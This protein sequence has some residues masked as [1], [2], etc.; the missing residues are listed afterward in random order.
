MKRILLTLFLSV[1]IVV[2]SQDKAPIS[3]KSYAEYGYN[4]TW[5]HY[6]SLAVIANFPINSY[7]SL[8]GG[9]N[10]NTS[11]VHALNTR[12]TVHFP[13]SVGNLT[14]ENRYLYRLYLRNNTQDFAVGVIVGY[15]KD[16]IKANLGVYSRV[17]GSITKQ[18]QN[19]SVTNIREPF[20]LIYNIE[21]QIFKQDH[22]WNIGLGIS[23][24]D[25]FQ[26]ERMYLPIVTLKGNFLPAQHFN[27]LTELSCK[28]TGI[29]HGSANFYAIYTRLGLIYTW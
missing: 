27:L 20:N 17:Y 14:L 21:G 6:G 2:F 29:L 8:E 28:P 24:Y 23:N 13:L 5:E 7:F 10:T 26:I 11:N 16:Y 25:D 18:G 22:N 3:L 12:A 15:V 4:Y 9:L 19:E 1:S